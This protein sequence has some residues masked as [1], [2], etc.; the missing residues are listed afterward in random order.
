VLDPIVGESSEHTLDGLKERRMQEITFLLAKRVLENYF[1]DS[2][3]NP[4]VWLFPQLVDLSKRWLSESLTC[5]SEAFPQL[6][7]L[8]Q[9]SQRAAEKIYGG[10]VAANTGRAV[11]KPILRPFE[12]TISTAIVDFDTI[13]PIYPT[14]K[15]H[16]NYVASHTKSWEQKLAQTL[17]DMPEVIAYVK[18]EG[19]RF[20]MPYVTEGKSANY[21]PD[22]IARVEAG[23][24]EPVNVIIEV[25]GQRRKEK[26]AKASTARDLWVPA[27]NNDGRFGRWTF[28][29]I[30]D[31]WFA[32]DRIREALRFGVSVNG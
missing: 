21:L 18:N 30:T 31:P 12:P 3:G 16:V 1:T 22:F 15:S 6:L 4:R 8:A 24:D 10:I 5:S 14:R 13:K 17:D 9:L 25:T 29:E 32:A 27:V 19:L 7:M 2:E 23:E 26:E 28:I 11:L 20:T